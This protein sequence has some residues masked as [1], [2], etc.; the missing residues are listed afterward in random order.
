[1][2]APNVVTAVGLGVSS[3]SY[4]IETE[5]TLMLQDQVITI[6]SWPGIKPGAA[7]MPGG[8]MLATTISR[9]Y[10]I[11]R[12]VAAPKLFYSTTTLNTTPE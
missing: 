11:A 6:L 8:D 3:P 5:R 4:Q 1:M 2:Q 7:C 9:E 10:T 12:Y